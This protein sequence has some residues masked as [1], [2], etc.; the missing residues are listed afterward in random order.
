MDNFHNL[1][2]GENKKKSIIADEK[3]GE[4]Y[5]QTNE[6]QNVKTCLFVNRKVIIACMGL[7][8]PTDHP[9]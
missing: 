4:S 1:M 7:R 6:K 8:F 3:S 9:A 2:N 5:K